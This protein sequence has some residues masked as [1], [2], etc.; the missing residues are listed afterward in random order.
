MTDLE[1]YIRENKKHFQVEPSEGHFDRFSSK[2]ENSGSKGR[3]VYLLPRMMKVAA[4]A[5]LIV[6]SGLW[7]FEKIT[8][9]NVQ[10]GIAL[11]DIS[12]EYQEV[13]Q[14]YAQK[15]SFTSREIDRSDMF[16]SEEQKRMVMQEL[17]DMDSIYRNLKKDLKANPDDERVINAMIEH[18]QLKL[19]I[20]NSILTQLHE[21]NDNNKQTDHENNEI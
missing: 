5:V 16:A 19:E 13:E 10:D 21:I 7:T 3:L 8:S 2:L 6:I 20:M 9:R 4:V 1:K 15:V 14:F 11:G 17:A 18:Y 12:P